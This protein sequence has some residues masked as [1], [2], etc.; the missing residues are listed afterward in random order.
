[1]VVF[2]RNNYWIPCLRRECEDF[3]SRCIKC[4]RESKKTVQQIMGD[5]PAVRVRPARAFKFTGVD[6][7]G[8]IN[9]RLSDK[10][11]H[12]TRSK[13]G[14][15]LK[16]YMVVFVCMITRAVYLD[17]V[18]G[19]SSEKFLEAYTRFVSRR[20]IPEVLY[21]DN[22]TNFFGANNILDKAV[23]SWPAN[24]EELIKQT[25]KSACVQE[26]VVNTGTTVWRFIPPGSPNQE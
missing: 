19:L 13:A 26:H 9:L 18:T 8:P 24:V 4:I 12:R 1:M 15:E 17:C 2:I 11:T 16:G 3:R 14:E 25:W 22:G 23:G 20:G 10:N 6:L 7:A 5:L 21:S